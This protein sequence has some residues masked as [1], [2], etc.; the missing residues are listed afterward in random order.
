M[1]HKSE[2]SLKGLY[3][4]TILALFLP[5]FTFDA[6]IMGYCWGY[7]FLPFF[8]IPTCIS[9]LFLF[10]FRSSIV[11][12]ILCQ[13]SILLNLG[14]L[15]FALGYWERFCN[16]REGFHL[17]DGLLTAQPGYWLALG[18]HAAFFVLFQI[19]LFSR[20]KGDAK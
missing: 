11:W 1:K 18:L 15:I 16:I 9:G 10:K 20:A 4:L 5:W 12:G 8:L 7:R 19:T 2:A 14:N 6:S 17:A 3:F 13:I